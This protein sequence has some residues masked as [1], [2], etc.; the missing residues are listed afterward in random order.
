MKKTI[1]TIALSLISMICFSQEKSLYH[2]ISAKEAYQILQTT[3]N[4]SIID[5]RSSEEYSSVHAENAVLITA[6]EMSDGTMRPIKE[7]A[8]SVAA[9]FDKSND[10]LFLICKTSGRS[11]LAAQILVDN[12]WNP[13]HIYSIDGG[14]LG[15]EGWKESNLPIVVK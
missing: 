6:F 10:K 11:K 8:E 9:K 7:F 1:T 13:D 4:T 14:T 12:G 5:V 2:N 15:K 3:K